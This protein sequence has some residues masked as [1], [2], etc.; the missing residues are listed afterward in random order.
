MLDEAKHFEEDSAKVVEGLEMIIAL[1]HDKRFD[2]E[3]QELFLRFKAMVE[4]MRARLAN[5]PEINKKPQDFRANS[6][7]APDQRLLRK[8]RCAAAAESRQS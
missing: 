1:R 7:R 2:K 8:P 6:C 4:R 3:W 5:K